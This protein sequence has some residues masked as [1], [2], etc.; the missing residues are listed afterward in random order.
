MIEDEHYWKERKLDDPR[1][2]WNIA[3]WFENWV[4]GYVLS[5]SHPHRLVIVDVVRKYGS[6]ESVLEVGCNTAPNL[7]LFRE[8]FRH[9]QD[10]NLAGI[11]V[12]EDALRKAKELMPV[13]N[14][15][16]GSVTAL[17]F[18]EKS[19]DVVLADAVLMYVPPD[20][21]EQVMGEICCVAKKI[22]VIV[23]WYDPVSQKGIMKRHHW[24][25]D[26][27]TLLA[28]FGW[29]VTARKLTHDEWPSENWT[30]LGYIFTAW[31]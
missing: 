21:I 30:E 12:N 9:L 17:P 26:Y 25:R 10:R 24:C 6:F 16:I 8:R 20:A 13:V 7:M 14:F 28:R 1:K 29:K 22:I 3:S 11:D 15:H 5:K 23:D 18:P 31:R 19:F 2:D 27:L 4:E